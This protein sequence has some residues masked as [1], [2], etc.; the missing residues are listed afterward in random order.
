MRERRMCAELKPDVDAKLRRC[1]DRRRELHRL[2]DS[3]RPMR[4]VT[5]ITIKAIPS[6]GAE[7]RYLLRFRREISQR[8]LERLP[9]GLHHRVTEW[10][11]DAPQPR[12]HALRFQCREHRF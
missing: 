7:K 10:M 3:A 9:L 2:P 6:N 5:G 11:I 12:E 1:V 8:I 4:R